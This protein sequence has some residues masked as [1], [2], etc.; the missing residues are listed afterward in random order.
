VLNN[1]SNATSLITK[2]ANIFK[3]IPEDK[4]QDLADVADAP[5]M[6]NAPDGRH[7]VPPAAQQPNGPCE[8]AS[9]GGAEKMVGHYADVTEQSAAVEAYATLARRLDEIEKGQTAIMR[10]FEALAGISKN[11]FPDDEAANADGHVEEDDDETKK[12]LG[13]AIPSVSVRQ[14]FESLSGR[15]QQASGLSRPP[16]F[17]KAEVQKATAGIDELIDDAATPSEAIALATLRA[18]AGPERPLRHRS[19]N[20]QR[21]HPRLLTR[22]FPLLDF[23]QESARLAAHAHPVGEQPG[24]SQA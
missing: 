1:A 23:V 13:G 22:V 11:R 10:A 17:M 14:F 21:R 9:G 15:A 3:A 18:A 12:A 7:R 20:K 24:L 4:L 6:W 19:G 16:S 2:L 5:D 8:S